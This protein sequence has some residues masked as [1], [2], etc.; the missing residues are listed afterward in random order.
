MPSPFPGMD[1]YLEPHWPDVHLSLIAEGRRAL[2]RSL[3]AGL[4][5]RSETRVVVE[6]VDEPGTYVP[7]RPDLRVVARSPSV[8]TSTDSATSTLV[9][10]AP[11]ELL[12]AADPPVE[13][14]LKVSDAAGMLLTVVE[15]LSPS[16]KVE[17]G[18][19]RFRRNRSE[20]LAAGVHWVEVDL[21]R[22]GNWRALMS[23]GRCPPSATSPYRAVARTA[24]PEGSAYLYPIHFRE[25][26]PDVQVPIREGVPPA[27]LPLQ[28]MLT[29]AYDDGRYGD[30]IDYHRPPDPALNLDDATW[31]ATLLAGRSP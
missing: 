23:P 1:P 31:A 6:P 24:G 4:V 17:P 18:L 11:Y 10:D 27:I 9:L 2:N 3:P 29:A 8:A 28:A 21:T 16:N 30:S 5:A 22:G 26:M 15:I 19:E 14:Y 20:M 13:R 7:V 12:V 25:P